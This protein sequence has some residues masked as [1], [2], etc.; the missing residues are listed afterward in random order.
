M[1]GFRGWHQH[2]NI[3]DY[4]RL[5]WGGAA[6][7]FLTATWGYLKAVAWK[8]CNLLVQQVEIHDDNCCQAVVSYL[9]AHHRRSGLYDR[10]YGA[11]YEHTR[12]GKYGLIPYEF[13]G[14]RSMI[15]WHRG[16]PFLFNGPEKRKDNAGAAPPAGADRKEVRCAITYVRG[17]LDVDRIVREAVDA[18]NQVAWSVSL[19]DQSA[20]RRFFIQHVPELDQ[21]DGGTAAPGA[22]TWWYRLPQYRLLAH[23]PDQLGKGRV[24]G[25]NSLEGL[26][27]PDRVKELLREIRIWRNHRDWYQ[28][29]GIPWKRGWLLFGVPG[30]GK[31][32]LARAFAEDLDL[33]IY[34]YDLADVGNHEFIR[35]WH[36]MQQNVPCIALIEDIDNVFH[37]RENVSA[38]RTGLLALGRRK[39]KKSKG[40]EEDRD[41]L[42]GGVLSFDVFLNCL[43]G[44]ER[45]D[46]VFTIIT[47][48]DVSKIDP[49]L[50]Q[51]RRLPDGSVEFISTRPGRIDKAIELTFMEPDDKRLMARRILGDYP[52][53]LE[54]MLEFIDRFPDLQETPAQFQERCAQVALA[55]FWEEQEGQEV[56]GGFGGA[57]F[58]REAEETLVG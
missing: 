17:T 13:F 12:D 48:N 2:K 23:T 51:P 43:D 56:D 41:D 4:F 16:F 57:R 49:A 14:K 47:T 22:S 46:G 54:D 31:T 28:R 39:K 24:E 29:R 10:T 35:A 36:A 8:V 25:K 18:R 44:V 19:K 45:S 42:G 32:A 52:P 37:G 21:K 27:F 20:R 55:C 5:L 58:R 30:T 40:E 50:G 26:I 3:M 6:L 33:P 15:L 9:I 1:P 53:A 7:G 34:V 38:A 11:A